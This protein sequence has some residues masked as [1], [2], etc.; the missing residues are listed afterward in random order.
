MNPSYSHLVAH[1][2]PLSLETWVS[3]VNKTITERPQYQIDKGAI[4]VG[5]VVARFLGVAVDEDEYYNQLFEYVHG[6]EKILTLLSENT[7]DK[8]IDN[9]HFQAIQRVLN[10]NQEQKLSINRL[11]AFL[12]G[13]QLL[14]KAKDP[15]LH[16]KLRE[17]MIAT[18]K[19]F[20]DRESEGLQH[21]E[22]RRVLVDLVKWSFNHLQPELEESN[23]NEH[24]P[25]FLWYGDFKKSHFYFAYYL[26]KVGCDLIIFS[27]SGRDILAEIDPNGEL[28]FI[29]KYPGQKE[30]EAF[31]T[32]R[33]N[34]K[35]TVAYRASREIETILNH[36]GSGLYKPWQ[37]RE[38]T[39]SSITLKT[40]YDE[41]FIIAKEIAMIRPDFEVSNG[42]VNIPN[43]FAKIQG[44]SRNRK[45]YWDRL[46]ALTASEASLLIKQF[47]FSSSV[48]NDFRFHYRDALERDGLLSTEKMIQ[49]NYWRYSHLPTG[50]QMGI[51]NAIRNICAKPALKPLNKETLDDVK[52]YLFTQ[53]MQIPANVLQLLQQF[54]YSQTVPKIILFNNELNGTMTRTDTALLLLLNQFGIDIILYNPP[55]HNDIENYV[56]EHLYDIHWLEDVVFNLDYREPS[57]V[58]RLFRQGFRR[59]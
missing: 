14:L 59:T 29:H 33:R 31:P 50:L 12:D 24:L 55:G 22:L 9:Q 17:A 30:A 35:A 7:L 27:P 58:K 42:V 15:A 6:E 47:P 20:A 44:V 36:E 13:E 38:Y 3:M 8:K 46:H 11:V 21:H 41:L 23:L 5:Q 40:T 10:I 56:E 26:M 25:K 51:A 32:E 2:L 37:L 19:L 18:L 16:R 4:H 49:S 48:N 28:S 57:I 54:D 43:V 1:I 34:R 52:I 45:E 53:G 39:P